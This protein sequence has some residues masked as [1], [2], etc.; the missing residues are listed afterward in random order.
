MGEIR[1]HRDL[2]AWQRA[3]DLVVRVYDLA[4]QWPKDEIYGLS[5]QAKRAAVSVPANI[6]E[7]YGRAGRASYV[8]FLKIAHGSLKELETHLD[9]AFRVGHMSGDALEAVLGDTETVGKLING[10]IR[11]LSEQ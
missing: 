2:I 8:H 6:A 11:K 4:S 9:V 1:S 10:L 7:G 5:A 3:M